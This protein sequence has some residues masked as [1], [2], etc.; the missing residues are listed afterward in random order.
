M[1]HGARKRHKSLYTYTHGVDKIQMDARVV[2]IHPAGSGQ[3]Q[4]QISSL[5]APTVDGVSPYNK[6]SQTL[7]AFISHQKWT[8]DLHNKI[9]TVICK[10]CIF[11]SWASTNFC[12]PNTRKK[13]EKDGGWCTHLVFHRLFWASTLWTPFSFC[14]GFLGD[15][16]LQEKMDR[17]SRVISKQISWPLKSLK[18]HCFKS[19]QS[20]L[21]HW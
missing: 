1:G 2:K 19:Q 20:L 6:S 3:S 10:K 14:F 17:S 12:G 8:P 15:N 21:P 16:K 13:E 7:R 9:S 11:L 5:F 4:N 18:I